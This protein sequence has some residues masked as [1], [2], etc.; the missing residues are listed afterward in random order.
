METNIKFRVPG[1]PVV[2]QQKRI[3]L[4]TMRLWVPSRTSLSGLRIRCCCELLCRLQ[5]SLG[6]GVAVALLYARSNSS[7]YT[8]SLGA[9]ICCGCGPKKDKSQKIIIIIK[10]N[11]V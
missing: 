6:C 1:V 10:I 7:D 2:T 4:G 9:S 11:K 5:M 3:R 8:P